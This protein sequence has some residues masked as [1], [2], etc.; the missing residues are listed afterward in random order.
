MRVSTER[1]FV[2]WFGLTVCV[3]IG[4]TWLLINSSNA[5][6]AFNSFLD[7]YHLDRAS[8][9]LGRGEWEFGDGDEDEVVRGQ[10]ETERQRRHDRQQQKEED[11]MGMEEEE[12]EE[13]HFVYAIGCGGRSSY[14]YQLIQ[15]LTLDHSF[16]IH[17]HYGTLT[18]IIT[19]CVDDEQMRKYLSRTVTNDEQEL[20]RFE[21]FF[22]EKS[23]EMP[24]GKPYVM[25]NRPNG[26]LRYLSRTTESTQADESISHGTFHESRRFVSKEEDQDDVYIILDPDFI[27]LKEF[28][29]SYVHEAKPLAG[30]YSMT[31]RWI[32]WGKDICQKVLSGEYD[33][34]S[35][36][37]RAPSGLQTRASLKALVNPT[38]CAVFDK[39][40]RSFSKA[41]Y[42]GGAPYVM[43]RSEWLVLL[44]RWLSIM[45][46]VFENYYDSIESDM[47]AWMIASA[48]SN[49]EY[50]IKREFMRTCMW[51]NNHPD[52]GTDEIFIHYCQRYHIFETR[53][54][55]RQYLVNDAAEFLP[56]AELKEGDERTKYVYTFSK[57]WMQ[58]RRQQGWLTDCEQPLLIQPPV[59]PAELKVSQ[60]MIN[61]E[62]VLK[63][64]IPA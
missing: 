14:K 36:Q 48:L 17:Q 41:H 16:F 9:K 45:P 62:R 39:I 46:V 44:P 12:E 49:I 4:N 7:F 55:D 32:N 6:F 60:R 8:G 30:Y 63:K 29:A 64:I 40:D 53:T 24:S 27:F 59:L 33:L 34:L 23:E 20:K 1:L 18:R 25:F 37:Y 11:G 2:L 31:S 57:Y 54:H 3:I 61:H 42:E 52:T 10:Q 22:T 43:R 51:G 28:S 19:G 38:T 13:V 26:L 15:A 5:P 21:V 35:K 56:A 47:F 58:A 50:S